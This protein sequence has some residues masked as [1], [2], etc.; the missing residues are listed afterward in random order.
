MDIKKEALEVVD[1]TA[2]HVAK[3]VGRGVAFLKSSLLRSMVL[4]SFAA[5]FLLTFTVWNNVYTSIN[6]GKSFDVFINTSMAVMASPLLL[7]AL[8]FYAEV[9]MRLVKSVAKFSGDEVTLHRRNLVIAAVAA[10]L[11]GWAVKLFFIP[12]VF[13]MIMTVYM[14]KLISNKKK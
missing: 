9:L 4:I 3:T 10:S 13:F 14:L 12:A 5:T 7:V 2:E 6:D 8:Y 11:A 1:E